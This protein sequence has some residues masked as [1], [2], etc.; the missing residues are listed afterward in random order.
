MLPISMEPTLALNLRAGRFND[1]E[2]WWLS[3]AG[4]RPGVSDA[5]AQAALTGVFQQTARTTLRNRRHLDLSTVNLVVALG[6]QGENPWRHQFAKIDAVL[7]V[8][9]WCCCLPVQ[10]LP[11]CCWRARGRPAEKA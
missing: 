9:H 8:L 7:T 4:I 3:I 5:Q 6:N 11:A 2:A 1:P 10:I